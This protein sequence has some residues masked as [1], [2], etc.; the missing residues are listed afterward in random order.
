MFVCLFGLRFYKGLGVPEPRSALTA[1]TWVSKIS[2]F[3]RPIAGKTKSSTYAHVLWTNRVQ[4]QSVAKGQIF[5]K[6]VQKI[7]LE[8]VS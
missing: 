8:R 3:T 5:V 4:W 1:P 2:E 7:K 6:V